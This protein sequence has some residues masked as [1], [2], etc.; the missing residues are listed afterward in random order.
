MGIRD[1]IGDLAFFVGQKKD[2]IHLGDAGVPGLDGE[3]VPNW[4][5]EFKKQIHGVILIAGESDATVKEVQAS[6][7]DTFNV[8]DNVTLHEVIT[9]E[10]SVRPGDQCGHE[11]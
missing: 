6:V 7:L 10:G 5:D 3:F 1:Y 9:L 8:G 2:A 11:Q 4:I